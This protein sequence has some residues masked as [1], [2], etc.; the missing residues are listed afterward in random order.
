MFS[1]KFVQKARTLLSYSMFDSF[2]FKPTS[3]YDFH[4]HFEK[5]S[6]RCF[7]HPSSIQDRSPN[8]A[9]LLYFCST[10][11][12]QAKDTEQEPSRKCIHKRAHQG[13]AQ[14][15]VLYITSTCLPS[16]K[17]FFLPPRWLP[18]MPS[19]SVQTSSRLNHR[20]QRRSNPCQRL[21]KPKRET[22]NSVDL[23]EG[24]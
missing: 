4:P 20:S 21:L 16:R 22:A 10:A 11:V 12:V 23:S 6:C 1:A 14:P 7:F 5:T 3:R 24:S 8:Q 2:D 17:F 13:N 19:P 18:S 15:T 9:G